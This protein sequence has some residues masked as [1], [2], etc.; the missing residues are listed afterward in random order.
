MKTDKKKTVIAL[1]LTAL[2][3]TAFCSCKGR[4]GK[5]VV[6]RNSEIVG[7]DGKGNTSGI[8]GTDNVTGTNGVGNGTAGGTNSDMNNSNDLKKNIPDNNIT[9]DSTDTANIP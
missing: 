3:L 2:T 5:D 8:N 9:K 7:T 1:T 6:D 4:D